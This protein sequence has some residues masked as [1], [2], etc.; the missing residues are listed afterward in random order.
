MG[1]YYWG[2]VNL[3]RHGILIPIFVGSSPDTP[4]KFPQSLKM[5]AVFAPMQLAVV[6]DRTHVVHSD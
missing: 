1:Y 5:T 4:T 2:I 6:M 3:V